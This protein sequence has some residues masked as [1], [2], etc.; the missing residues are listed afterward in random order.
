VLFLSEWRLRA[1]PLQ[2]ASHRRHLGSDAAPGRK[3]PLQEL[4]QMSTEDL[5]RALHDANAKIS[6]L[7]AYTTE[8][9]GSYTSLQ[10]QLE[11]AKAE[12]SM[13][14]DER[15]QEKERVIAALR[16]EV[17]RMEREMSDMEM[18]GAENE[19]AID[20]DA[21]DKLDD[22]LAK[23]KEQC[24]LR[25]AEIKQLKAME[26]AARR[27]S[28]GAAQWR[29]SAIQACSPACVFPHSSCTESSTH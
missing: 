21:L 15:L 1:F 19:S 14:G 10:R 6:D 16:M 18:G 9:D 5:A 29:E 20:Y 8:L 27:D 13:S 25:D 11:E 3:A 17:E 26:E 22:E 4:L 7:E 28:D 24:L 12:N 23:A 2:A